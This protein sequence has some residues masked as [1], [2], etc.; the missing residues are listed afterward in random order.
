[1]LADVEIRFVLGLELIH[2]GPVE[3][4]SHIFRLHFSYRIGFNHLSL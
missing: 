3:E 4:E 2:F 1:M